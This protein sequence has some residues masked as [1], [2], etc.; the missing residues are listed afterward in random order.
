M[1]VERKVRLAEESVTIVKV[2]LMPE[3][4]DGKGRQS[5]DQ[6]FSI[7]HSSALITLTSIV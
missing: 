5:V 3:F 1:T 6:R 4:S 2:Y 7:F